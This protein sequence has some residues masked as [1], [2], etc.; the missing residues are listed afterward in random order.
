MN[1]N[2]DLDSFLESYADKML[3]VSS[4]RF[5]DTESIPLAESWIRSSFRQ[6]WSTKM[7]RCNLTWLN[8]KKLEVKLASWY[9]FCSPNL[10]HTPEQG[11]AES[12]SRQFSWKLSR[13]ILLVFL[14]ERNDIEPIAYTLQIFSE[15]DA[16]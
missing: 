15:S 13:D 9:L 10:L 8:S 6:C 12:R 16:S 7:V 5:R 4:D 3:S 14:L 1:R 2:V 11:E